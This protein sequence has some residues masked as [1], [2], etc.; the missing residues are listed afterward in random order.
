MQC[1]GPIIPGADGTYHLFDPVYEHASLWHVIYYAHGTAKNIHGPYDWSSPN[2]TSNA[3]N[4]AALVFPNATTGKMVY[5]LWI[6]GDIW[7]AADAAGPYEKMYKNPMPSNTA[8]AFANGSIYVTNQGTTEVMTS[9]SLA[10]PWS[11]FST[12]N[13]PKGMK[14]TVED[15]YM[16][17]D[18][19]GAHILHKYCILV[20][21]C[22]AH[23]GMQ[24][25]AFW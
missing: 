14:Y 13:H 10:G 17:V 7:V 5:S 12:V 25:V 23:S 16:Y 20:L 8:P 22:T 6:G 15:P 18:P 1:S 21:Y 2:I 11:K 9:T 19:Q 4:P 3:I 24:L